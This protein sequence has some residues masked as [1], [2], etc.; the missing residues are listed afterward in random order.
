MCK[1][2]DV[3]ILSPWRLQPSSCCH[4]QLAVVVGRGLVTVIHPVRVT[5]ESL[6]NPDLWPPWAAHMR[7]NWSWDF[8]EVL[9]IIIDFT[10]LFYKSMRDSSLCVWV[11]HRTW[12]ET[13]KQL[14]CEQVDEF[15]GALSPPSLPPLCLSARCLFVFHEVEKGVGWVDVR[16]GVGVTHCRPLQASGQIPSALT[17]TLTIAVRV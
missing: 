14:E 10:Q 16:W 3:V 8:D 12:R 17:K 6:N 13:N 9:K 7:L 11:S 4:W 2:L 15:A 1:C 5:S